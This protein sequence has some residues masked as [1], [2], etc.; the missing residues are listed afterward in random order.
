[1]Y[2]YVG[3]LGFKGVPVD[4]IPENV[5]PIGFHYETMA[6]KITLKILFHT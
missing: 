4:Q 3:M 6:L 2:M 5:F 1:M